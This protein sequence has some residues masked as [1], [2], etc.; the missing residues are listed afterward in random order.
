MKMEITRRGLL[1]ATG[2]IVAAAAVSGCSGSNGNGDQVLAPAE[3]LVYDPNTET[4]LHT[5]G[6]YN[7]GSRCQQKVHVKNGKVVRFTSAGDKQRGSDADAQA[8]WDGS[9]LGKPMELRACVRC[10]GG[11]QGILYQPDRLKYPLMRDGT[12]PK[13]DPNGF[14]RVSWDTALNA[15]VTKLKAAYDRADSE[16]LPYAPVISH[17]YYW[18]TIAYYAGKKPFIRMY[19][20]ESYGG[21]DLGKFDTVGYSA[22]IN[23]RTDR[24]NTKFMITWALDTTR[25][26]YWNIHTHFLN[27]KVKENGIPMVVIAANHSD[28]A[29]VLSSGLPNYAYTRHAD[30][31]GGNN[32]ISIPR[33]IG[34]RPATDAA[35][36]TALAYV[37]YKNK[38]YSAA[39]LTNPAVGAD[40]SAR[41]CF[42]FWENDTV[43]SQGPATGM[44]RINFPIKA[45]RDIVPSDRFNADGVSLSSGTALHGFKFRVPAGESYQEYLESREVEWAGAPVATGK[46]SADGYKYEQPAVP[47]NVGEALD[48]YTKVLDYVSCLTGV[49]A[50]VIEA[51]AFKYSEYANHATD[52]AFIETGGGPQRAWN[53]S[54]WVWSMFCLSAMCGYV[55]KSGGGL[56]GM[57]MGSFS[58]SLTF[59]AGGVDI[60]SQP[61]ATDPRTAAAINLELASWQHVVLTGKD[62][63][64]K[65]DLINDVKYQF[66]FDITSYLPLQ[67]DIVIHSNMNNIMT[68]PNSSKNRAAYMK[69]PTLVVID[70]VMTPTAMMADIVLP[71]CTHLE[72][73]D[74]YSPG[75]GMSTLYHRQKAVDVMYDTWPEDKI[76]TELWNRLN[77]AMNNAGGPSPLLVVP[78]DLKGEEAFTSLRLTNLYKSSTG[79]PNAELPSLDT[80]KQEG[81]YTVVTPKDKPIVPM[82][83]Y[84]PSG[85]LDTSTGFINFYSPM[86]AMR[87]G[88]KRPADDL[89][90]FLYYPGGWR[91][92][93]ACYQPVIQGY[94]MFFDRSIP[95]ANPLGTFTGYNSP[96]S[97]RNYKLYYMTNKSRNRGHTVFDGVAAIKDQFPQVVKINPSTAG[98]RGIK[99]GDLVYIYNDRGCIKIPAHLTQQILPGVVSIEHGAWY[100]PSSTEMVK[101]W[102]QTGQDIAN[103]DKFF[104]TTAPVDLGGND[105]VLTNDYFGEDSLWCGGAVPAQSGPCEISLT[106]PE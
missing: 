56:A 105:N 93:T 60:Y 2:A 68:H 94:E 58:E 53:A 90:D 92:A 106:K 43:V 75:L 35:L 21:V 12:K 40:Q 85:T 23:S 98:E 91:S 76:Q 81:S 101:V 19:G 63:R 41:K 24:Y 73:D 96:I 59:S 82:K 42:G 14:K 86:R 44:D 25:T 66:G 1:Q 17:Y 65:Q 74:S 103:P 47:A 38:R 79:Q 7:C 33:W 55:E 72:T 71:A 13:G 29:A 49:N 26:T 22:S 78:F 100:R 15:V 9:E 95:S 34:C 11:Y 48:R 97:G 16:N 39:Y 45:T 89:P 30:L 46:S 64:R 20:N 84:T 5:T 62:H 88:T 67:V 31:G 57:S 28:A 50:G 87:P 80:L 32:T 52:A 77:A 6:P 51:L 83:T 10:Y 8:E 61:N 104:E 102:M 37:I 18:S 54:E 36:A 4:I 3:G 27:A 99:E 69:V 70:Q